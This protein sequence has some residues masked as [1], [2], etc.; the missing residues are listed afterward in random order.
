AAGKP[1]FVDLT[2]AWCVSCKVNEKRVLVSKPFEKALTDTDTVYM[3][4]DWTNQDVEISSYLSLF[5]RSG[6]PLYVYYG[7]G[8]SDAKILPQLLDT[9]DVVKT[10]R[11][12]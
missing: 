1:V 5:G 10:L 4:G 9:N 11:G 7:P 12:K 2:A 6:V 3:V 8:N